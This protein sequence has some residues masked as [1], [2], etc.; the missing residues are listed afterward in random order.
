MKWQQLLAPASRIL[1]ETHF[2]PRL[3]AQGA[4][5]EIS[6]DLT[7]QDGTR[8]P[9]LASALRRAGGAGVVIVSI[10]VFDATE[11][12]RFEKVLRAARRDAE[13]AAEALILSHK[14]LRAEHERLR[15]LLRSIADAVMTT[16]DQGRITTFNPSAETV[17]G[18]SAAQALGAPVDSIGR[19]F[20]AQSRRLIDLRVLQRE[21]QSQSF[22]DFLLVRADGTE[23]YIE[24]T[25]APL[26]DEAN[27]G[28]GGVYVWRDV[29][30]RRADAAERQFEATH[31]PL[32]RLLNRREFERLIN[33]ELSRASG[34]P[35]KP[36]LLLH[37]G[38]DQFKIVND[39][40][41]ATAGDALL[42][43]IADLL[44]QSLR[45]G[46]MLARLG[47]DE[48][49][50]LLPRCPVGAGTTL[51]DNLRQRIEEFRF[52][53]GESSHMLTASIGLAVLP[54]GKG[55]ADG[56]LASAGMAC[57]AAKEA[58]RN[59]VHTVHAGDA[60]IQRRR[61]EMGWVARI[62]GDLNEDRFELFFQS[63]VRV[64]GTLDGPPHGELLLR[65]RDD[66]GR[67]VPPGA[68]ISAAERYHQMGHIDRWVVLNAFSWLDRHAGVQVSINLSGQSFGDAD[69]L[70]YVVEQMAG[71][72][73]DPA[74]V[75][76]EITE[77][78]AIADLPA[79]LRFIACLRQ[80]G[81][82]FSLDDFG[83]GLSSF[84][85]LRS[86]PVD[87][88]KI[89]GSFVKTMGQD[90]VNREI[91]ESI[92]RVA[93]LCG[94]KTVAE[95]VEDAAILAALRQIGVDYAQGWGVGKPVPLSEVDVRR[96]A[97][98]DAAGRDLPDCLGSHSG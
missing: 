6:L 2:V 86:L 87:F 72:A 42:L 49:G 56:A 95:W 75:C 85:Y 24:G 77:T 93:K 4:V 78:A 36:H 76:F 61:E 53:H 74:R 91:V 79:A 47:S 11:T 35:D 8:F 5:S 20:E 34:T 3:E 18:L 40:A 41:G 65:L 59:R 69:F 9:I 80:R 28:E 7:R 58:G 22:S 10:T 45:Q 62:R 68:F 57:Q 94:L 37:I 29:T 98:G 26:R 32:T 30:Q 81:C 48:F 66:E 38:L 89:D 27:G 64:D 14:A 13:D 23:R 82:L 17:T 67:L 88:V 63:I 83:A 16:D 12:R 43:E 46:D 39:T 73:L 21:G 31:D 44:R 84:G 70:T 92:H 15:V 19:V 55:S 33:F 90:P 96:P 25:A 54:E 50:V 60:E 52:C 97:R 1:Y 71:R 51:A